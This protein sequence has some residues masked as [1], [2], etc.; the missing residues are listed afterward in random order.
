MQGMKD[1]T[2]PVVFLLASGIQPSR[3]EEK[4]RWSGPIQHPLL[5]AGESP[6]G[7]QSGSLFIYLFVYM[8]PTHLSRQHLSSHQ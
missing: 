5:S 2:T 1:T 6:Y 3:N 7:G 4:P 8:P